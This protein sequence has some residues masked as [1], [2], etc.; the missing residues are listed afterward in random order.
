MKDS[1]HVKDWLVTYIDGTHD[2]VRAISLRD[3]ANK[4]TDA[5][6][7][8]LESIELLHTVE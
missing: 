5:S 3:A 6:D 8:P 2:H 7:K 4:V 1:E